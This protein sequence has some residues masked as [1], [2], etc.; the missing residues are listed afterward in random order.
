MLIVLYAYS[1]IELASRGL[2]SYQPRTCRPDVH[3]FQGGRGSRAC[4]RAPVVNRAL[5]QTLQEVGSLKRMVLLCLI[6]D[7]F[8]DDVKSFCLCPSAVGSTGS[9]AEF[10]KPITSISEKKL[11]G[12]FFFFFFFFFEKANLSPGPV[13]LQKRCNTTRL[14][15]LHW[16]NAL[17]VL[18]VKPR[19]N[20]ICN[21]G[22]PMVSIS[23]LL[24]ASFCK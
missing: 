2:C 9:I 6:A 20:A 19:G 16:A 21:E 4:V 3:L 17:W 18:E 22:I 23:R 12:G 14:N 15:N 1:Y 10:L 5:L 8:A 24:P 11:Q 13:V 7:A